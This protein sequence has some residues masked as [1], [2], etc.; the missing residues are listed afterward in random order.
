MSVLTK[1]GPKRELDALELLISRAGKVLHIT[2]G[3]KHIDGKGH[4]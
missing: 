1:K 4:I 2:A 3:I